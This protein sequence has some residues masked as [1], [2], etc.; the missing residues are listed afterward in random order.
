MHQSIH[1]GAE[2]T[3]RVFS[4]LHL[5]D[6]ELSDCDF[7]DCTWRGC[8]LQGAILSRIRFYGC[9]FDN[10]DMRLLQ[11]LECSF[12][13]TNFTDCALTGIDWT[14][15]DWSATGLGEPLSFTRCALNHSTF[16]GLK[17][18]GLQVIESQAREVDFRGAILIRA[19][20]SGSDLAS[21][22]FQSSDL[23]QA[24]L[25]RA[26]NYQL[27]PRQNTLTGCKFSLPEALSLL[28][29]LDIKLV[30]T[31]SAPFEEPT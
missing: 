1:S 31:G 23:S 14:R 16:I 26:R 28:Y 8:N 18:P 29:S 24:D 11:V 10:C 6:A 27:D 2:Y 22:L 5:K 4:D 30:D 17:L 7:Y 15:A 12:R 20:F 13:S 21:I 19:D 25:S 9:R 3:D